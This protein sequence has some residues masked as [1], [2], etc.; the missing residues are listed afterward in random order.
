MRR[1]L[2]GRPVKAEKVLGW[3]RHVD[4]DSLIKEM[5]ESDLKASKS[6]VEDQN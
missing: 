5:V 2:L 6:L 4:F 1:Q 3:K